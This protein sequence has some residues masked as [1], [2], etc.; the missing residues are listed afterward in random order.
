MVS[1]FIYI[2]E[3]WELERPQKTWKKLTLV[4]RP[5][6]NEGSVIEIVSVTINACSFAVSLPNSE[7]NSN[8][9]KTNMLVLVSLPPTVGGRQTE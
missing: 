5:Q 9:T 1:F 8:A 2:R 3:T 7:G 6:K 4:E